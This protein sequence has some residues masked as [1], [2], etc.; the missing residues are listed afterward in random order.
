MEDINK[1][2]SYE[3]KNKRK[4]PCA[5]EVCMFGMVNHP[6]PSDPSIAPIR[7]FMRRG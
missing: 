5:G 7:I 3:L 1:R 4:K 6:I 2:I